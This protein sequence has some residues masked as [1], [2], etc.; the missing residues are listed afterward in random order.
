[1]QRL[2]FTSS[3]RAAVAAML[4]QGGRKEEDE[5]QGLRDALLAPHDCSEDQG[6]EVSMLCLGKPGAAGLVPIA[7]LK[8]STCSVGSLVSD[9]QTKVYS[10]LSRQLQRKAAKLRMHSMC[11]DSS[12]YC[13]MPERIH[14]S[15]W[16]PWCV[17]PSEISILW[18]YMK[19]IQIPLGYQRSRA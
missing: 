16:D 18:I 5:E 1:M 15:L 6:G 10:A 14:A 13:T 12:P 4:G 11:L 7:H 3:L 19:P 2:G 8:S 9:Q 17:F